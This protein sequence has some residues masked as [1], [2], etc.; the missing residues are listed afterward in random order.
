MSKTDEEKT[1]FVCRLGFYQFEHMP[2]GICGAPATFQRVME[3][4]MR[5]FFEGYSVLR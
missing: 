4:T 5:E 3:R 1:A 2:Q